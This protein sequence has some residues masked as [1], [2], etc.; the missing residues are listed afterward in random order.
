M[1]MVMMMVMVMLMVM[2]MMMMVIMMMMA[3]MAIIITTIITIII[4]FINITITIIIIIII[5][6]IGLPTSSKEE[7][8]SKGTFAVG[9]PFLAVWSEGRARAM[10]DWG[11][12][13]VHGLRC[14][15]QPEGSE[16]G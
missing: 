5:I 12:Q 15:L 3:K 8:H 9:I 1:L 10:A 13:V 14:A 11:V 6:I 16:G 7:A 4:T 2:K